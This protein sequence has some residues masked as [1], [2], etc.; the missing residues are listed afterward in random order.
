MAF[1]R[2][3]IVMTLLAGCASDLAHDRSSDEES[4]YQYTNEELFIDED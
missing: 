1:M 3:T 2:V 4:D